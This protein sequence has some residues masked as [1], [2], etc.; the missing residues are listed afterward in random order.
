MKRNVYTVALAIFVNFL[1]LEVTLQVFYR[2][3]AGDWLVNR[4]GLPI[5][6][7]D[8]HRYY[9]VIPN[10][11]YRSVTNEYD[12]TYYTDKWGF[13][14]D[15]TRR[16]TPREKAEDA[17]RI[18]YLGP[19]FTFGS[20]GN[21]EDIYTTL[22]ARGV[23]VANKRVEVVN[24][25]TPGQPPGLQLCWV[26]AVGFE[27]KPDLVIQTVYGSP[28]LSETVCRRNLSDLPVIEDGYL[29][30][31]PPT[32]KRE[33]VRLAKKSAVAFYTWYLWQ[34][35]MSDGIISE[36]LGGNFYKEKQESETSPKVLNAPSLFKRYAKTIRTALGEDVQIA[37]IYVPWSFV[38][39]PS[40]TSR[41]AHLGVYDYD[42]VETIRNN[43]SDV[44]ELLAN[45]FITF[46]NPLNLLMERDK[47]ERTYYFIDIHFTPLGN[48]AVAQ[49]AI[50]IVQKL[51]E[52]QL[53]GRGEL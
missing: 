48:E 34:L 14:S 30:R 1:V 29:L 4:A 22:I 18:L 15:A 7:Y 47:Y 20:A 21:Y 49:V 3:T 45:D 24:L 23:K 50:P 2:V 53:R 13:R 16:H 31:E 51:I 6:S 39:R 17:Y 32:L 19:S 10:L 36:S 12:V 8:E 42:R 25:G 33:L 37:F 43:A 38:V 52:E 46:I 35:A 9:K 44:G 26:E 28:L 27:F 41:W 40:D 11:T 5:F